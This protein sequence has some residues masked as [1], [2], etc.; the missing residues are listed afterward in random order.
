MTFR[1][2]LIHLMAD[3]NKRLKSRTS[4][5]IPQVFIATPAQKYSEPAKKLY[6][7]SSP[8]SI[9]RGVC[10]FDDDNINLVKDIIRQNFED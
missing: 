10:K 6:K 3:R 8:I 2:M 1:L 5:N 7:I 4:K 9:N